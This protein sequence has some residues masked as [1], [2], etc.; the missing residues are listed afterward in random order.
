M[1]AASPT[2]PQ[3]SRLLSQQGKPASSLFIGLMSGTSA[4]GVDAVLMTT[5]PAPQALLLVSQPFSP[6]LRQAIEALQQPGPNELERAAD[7]ANALADAY[8]N[9]ARALLA[10]ARLSASDIIAIGAHGQT[11]R[12]KPERGYTLQILNAARLAETTGIAVVHDLRSVDVAAGGQGAPLVPAFHASVFGSA[13]SRRAIVNIGGI[14]NV[15]LIPRLRPDQ[16]LQVLGYDTGPGNTLLD[17]WSA[18]HL[19]T[20]FDEGGR[21]AAGGSPDEALLNILLGDHYFGQLPPKRTGRDLFN[22]EWLER[23]LRR[24]PTRPRPQ[25]VQ[26]TLAEL[27]ALTI[28]RACEGHAKEIYL[29][30]GGA[31]NRDLVGRLCRLLPDITIADTGVLGIAPMAVEA[32]AF[33]WLAWRRVTS[34]SG[35]LPAVTGASGFRVLGSVTDPWGSLASTPSADP[36]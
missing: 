33:A 5:S 24:C 8:A 12:H 3:R 29:C 18:R 11:V 31:F 26:A 7:L 19:G 13:D 30:G 36:P 15:S 23:A 1:S 22:A 27:T 10:E 16:P 14:A 34:Q 6:P 4:D 25:D 32:A 20:A 2:P 28:S 9:S 21:W 35:N 17:Y